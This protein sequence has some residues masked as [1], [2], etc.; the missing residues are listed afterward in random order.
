MKR[1][2]VQNDLIHPGVSSVTI[3]NMPVCALI[4]RKAFL[5]VDGYDPSITHEDW[6]LWLRCSNSGAKFDELYEAVYL[7]NDRHTRN[8]DPQLDDVA[9]QIRA[10]NIR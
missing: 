8:L 1:F 7:I 4:R 3:N 5:D 9:R 6:D 2:G 10:A